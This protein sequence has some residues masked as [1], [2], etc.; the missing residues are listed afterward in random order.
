MDDFESACAS[1]QVFATGCDKPRSPA[2]Q[3]FVNPPAEP[4]RDWHRADII[5]AI[6]KTGTT[7]SA[8]SRQHG[9]SSS[10]LANALTRKWPRAEQ[11]IAASLNIPPWVI[12]PS[13]YPRRCPHGKSAPPAPDAPFTLLIRWQDAN[14]GPNIRE[15]TAHATH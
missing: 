3:P 13:R 14:A 15:E 5:A 1:E 4:L 8:L 2:A 11:I 9:L 6:K 7:L 10:T 12:W